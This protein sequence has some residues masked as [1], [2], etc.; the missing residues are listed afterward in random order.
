M[1]IP[2][3]NAF[4]ALVVHLGAL[5]VMLEFMDLNIY[6]VVYA[7]V[8]F[9]FLMCILNGLAISKHLKYRQE[10]VKTFAIPLLCATVMGVIVFI[11]YRLLSMAM[12]TNLAGEIVSVL[13]S[14]G[15]GVIVYFVLLVAF[16][17]VSERELSAVPFGRVLVKVLK[18]IR[19]LP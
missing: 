8:I 4:I 18:A 11:S 16:R 2:V 6:A 10:K 13:V 14:T 3:R 12:G 9:S 15:I 17:G 5:Y 19:I 7:N 1:K